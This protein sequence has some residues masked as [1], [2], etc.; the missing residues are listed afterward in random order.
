MP[1]LPTVGGDTN[2]WGA[3][4]NEY[5]QSFAIIPDAAGDG[6]T[7]DT[8]AIQTALNSCASA[9]GGVVYLPLGTY[10]ISSPLQMQNR[11][12]LRGAGRG[13]TTIKVDDGA[14]CTAIVS[15]YLH[16]DMTVSD[17]TIDGNKDNQSSGNLYG[18]GFT[19]CS[20]TSIRNVRIENPYSGGI[21]YGS[22]SDSE[23]AFCELIGCGHDSSWDFAI[24]PSSSAR[25]R[26]I[27][28]R[29]VDPEGFGIFLA[30]SPS[31]DIIIADNHISGLVGNHIGI[32][33]G[34]AS[35]GLV[36]SGNTVEIPESNLLAGCIDTGSCYDITVVGN[37]CRG[38]AGGVVCDSGYRQLISGNSLYR[39]GETGISAIGPTDVTRDILIS[40][41]LVFAA[42]KS[43]I[44]VDGATGIV[45]ADNIV[46]N[47]A[48][49]ES[50]TK[51][52]I[53]IQS[54]S[55][56]TARVQVNGN[57]CYD[58]QYSK[59]QGYGLYISGSSITDIRVG[60]DNDFTGNLT[61]DI[62]GREKLS[63]PNGGQL[64]GWAAD[65]AQNPTLGVLP[66][67]TYV[68]GVRIHVTE[69]FNSDGTDLLSVGYDADADAFATDTDVSTTGVKTVTLG[70]LAGYNGTA[71]TVEAY[72]V[73]GGTEPTI[74]SALPVVEYS[75]VP[76]Q[77]A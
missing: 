37:V 73:N 18:I 39:N 5:I 36:V 62:Y 23:I 17:L 32:A 35:Y 74:T 21:D 68:T 65:N 71:R 56:A 54:T 30:G 69:A 70:A 51:H 27:G 13:A 12:W 46:R 8:T 67:D 24:A 26:I 75:G 60:D 19:S 49:L 31:H 66:A 59:T 63:N 11:T 40:S 44:G 50:G 43:G 15:T 76:P 72:Y 25:L 58:D 1:T 55:V 77:V 52:G 45:I 6:A 61:G 38:G 7:D 47:C 29:I 22:N 48:R 4:L 20:R 10:L 57:R 3:E 28:N 41:N 53:S 9:G 33:L 64:V 14:N 16:A 34:S 42:G 2:T